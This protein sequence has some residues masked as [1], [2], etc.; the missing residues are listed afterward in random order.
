MESTPEFKVIVAM[1]GDVV[2]LQPLDHHAV[3]TVYQR[4]RE[5]FGENDDFAMAIGAVIIRKT[6][7]GDSIRY[8]FIFKTSF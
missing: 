4:D 2:V 5:G 3:I 1:P 6:D 8:V 7:L